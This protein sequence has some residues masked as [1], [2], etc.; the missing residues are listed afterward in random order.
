[1]MSLFQRAGRKNGN[2]SQYQFWQLTN[3]GRNLFAYQKPPTALATA[4]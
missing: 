1:M 3:R 2:K 4:C